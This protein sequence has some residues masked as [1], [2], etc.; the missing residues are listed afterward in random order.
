MVVDNLWITP[1]TLAEAR[2]FKGFNVNKNS[3]KTFNLK[4]KLV[5]NVLSG[6]HFGD[7]IDYLGREPRVVQLGDRYSGILQS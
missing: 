5:E 3:W 7:G 6:C 1:K 4:L 2:I